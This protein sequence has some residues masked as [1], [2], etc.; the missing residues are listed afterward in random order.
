MLTH[1]LVYPGWVLTSDLRPQRAHP[2]VV[3]AVLAVAPLNLTYIGQFGSGLSY[4]GAQPPPENVNFQTGRTFRNA[5]GGSSGWNIDNPLYGSGLTVR[6][7]SVGILASGK[8]D[9]TRGR[10][11]DQGTGSGVY[12]VGIAFDPSA[13]FY[14]AA[15]DTSNNV[16]IVNASTSYLNMESGFACVMTLRADKKARMYLRTKSGKKEYGEG[17]ALAGTPTNL[18]T[19]QQFTLLCNQDTPRQPN[20]WGGVSHFVVWPFAL[21]DARAWQFADNPLG[22][23]AGP[24]DLLSSGMAVAS[25]GGARSRGL[26]IQ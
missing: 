16:S 15:V 21:D 19:N 2:M 4:D 9:G 1:R 6:E 3:D 7:Y 23:F 22:N 8:Y 5:S 20:V 10:L 12:T 13:V 17:A 26:I 25:G 14:A 11:V 24:R 18:A